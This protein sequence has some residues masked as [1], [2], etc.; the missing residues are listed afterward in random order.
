[1]PFEEKLMSGTAMAQPEASLRRTLIVI[2]ALI[3]GHL[4]VLAA[5]A[6]AMAG[7]ISVSGSQMYSLTV[8]VATPFVSAISLPRS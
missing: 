4:I 7:A 2:A 6:G 3:L 5:A 8:P 1:M